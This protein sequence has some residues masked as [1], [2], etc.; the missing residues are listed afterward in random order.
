MS[1]EYFSERI[2]INSWPSKFYARFEWKI[3][4]EGTIQRA[5][6]LDPRKYSTKRWYNWLTRSG[7]NALKYASR[8]EKPWIPSVPPACLATPT[9]IKKSIERY[10]FMPWDLLLTSPESRDAVERY[11][12]TPS[13][14]PYIRDLIIWRPEDPYK[15]RRFSK[16][17]QPEFCQW[18]PHRR[19]PRDVEV[20]QI[21]YKELCLR[22]VIIAIA[23][24]FEFSMETRDNF[25]RQISSPSRV[26]HL[27]FRRPL[28]P[29]VGIC[30][31]PYPNGVLLIGRSS[32]NHKA[33]RKIK[34]HLMKLILRRRLIR[35]KP[36]FTRKVGSDPWSIIEDFLH[37]DESV[38]TSV[39][40]E[41]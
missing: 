41:K 2:Y 18:S 19:N 25:V 14:S 34:C 35:I 27:Y 5:R 7:F 24:F 32:T 4:Q 20:A 3:S 22:P 10:F 15:E 17:A 37:N 30:W 1:F 12:R 9:E 13:L 33:T 21:L 36:F 39:A 31:P 28:S 29:G 6:S 16:S 38:V 23:I 11:S 8:R 26:P 40:L